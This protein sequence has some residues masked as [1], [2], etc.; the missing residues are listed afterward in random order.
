MKDSL[1]AHCLS[2]G[3]V[4]YGG[5]MCDNSGYLENKSVNEGCKNFENDA[6]QFNDNVKKAKE[7]VITETIKERVAS[8][9]AIRANAETSME[10]YTEGMKELY[11]QFLKDNGLDGYIC[12]KSNLECKGERVKAF[13]YVNEQDNGNI[14]I[15]YKLA[16]KEYADDSDYSACSRLTTD[17]VKVM[18]E[19]LDN[20]VPYYSFKNRDD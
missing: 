12:H 2:C 7:P 20:Y 3:E 19:I 15:R 6:D 10:T 11:H 17:P 1:C 16:N 13:L 18:Q 4:K 8:L 9:S 5:F 14:E